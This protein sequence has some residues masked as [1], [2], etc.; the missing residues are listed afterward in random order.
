[1]TLPV[2]MS[3][4]ID[5]LNQPWGILTAGS[6]LI[7]IPVMILFYVAQRYLI[8]GMTTGGVKG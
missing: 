4:F 1:M 6:V 2:G 7:T 3:T 8:S 5:P